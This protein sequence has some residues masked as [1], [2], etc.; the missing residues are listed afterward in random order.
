[1]KFGDGDIQSKEL[2][3][4][5]LK[6]MLTSQKALAGDFGYR[7]ACIS[8]GIWGLHWISPTLPKSG[9][10][11]RHN[12]HKEESWLC[13]CQDDIDLDK[14][15]DFDLNEVPTECAE[16]NAAQLP[17]HFG[18]KIFESS[19]GEV[20]ETMNP[21]NTNM[22]YDDN[23]NYYS[24]MGS[25]IRRKNELTSQHQDIDL[26]MGHKSLDANDWHLC[27]KDWEV[28]SSD[29]PEKPPDQLEANTNM[30]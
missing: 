27:D 17:I 21:L 24:Y 3:P 7:P 1:M 9:T 14:P 8:I 19:L 5:G 10:P 18:S 22:D 26:M 29:P 13:E 4:P 6:N 23:K 11:E 20:K 30:L 16:L 15:K 2:R 28:R 25:K 12:I